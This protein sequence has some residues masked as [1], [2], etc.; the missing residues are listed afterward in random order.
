MR[1][2]FF[3]ADGQKD[4]ETGGQTDA[5]TDMTKL[6]VAFRNFANSA[7]TVLCP[8]DEQLV[9][10]YQLLR[11]QNIPPGAWMF[12]CCECCQVEVSATG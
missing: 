6:I 10:E 5:R 1:V 2:E 11:R 8:R 3:H 4:G 7:K 12:V 9:S